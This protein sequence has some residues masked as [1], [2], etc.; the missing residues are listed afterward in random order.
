MKNARKLVV[1]TIAALAM[2]ILSLIVVWRQTGS[3]RGSGGEFG[4]AGASGS[5]PRKELH[6]PTNSIG[7]ANP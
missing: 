5:W 4:G 6:R 2:I 1:C 3:H 7:D